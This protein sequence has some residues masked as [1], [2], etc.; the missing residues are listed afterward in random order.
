MK[1]AHAGIVVEEEPQISL[2]GSVSEKGSGAWEY[3]CLPLSLVNSR[4]K[5]DRTARQH[6]VSPHPPQRIAMIVP[7]PSAPAR[8]GSITALSGHP[9][10]ASYQVHGDAARFAAASTIM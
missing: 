8:C 10:R 6:S 5:R 7:T 3:A 2:W 4:R 9:D 1:R